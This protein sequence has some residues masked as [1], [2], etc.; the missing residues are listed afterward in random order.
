[1]RLG[2]G[3]WSDLEN[4]PQSQDNIDFYE[5]MGNEFF[6]SFLFYIWAFE[7]NEAK[8]MGISL[9]GISIQDVP[10][11]YKKAIF[12]KKGEKLRS[13]FFYCK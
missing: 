4:V 1:M 10:F 5:V 7:R 11:A 13:S 2:L 12:S 3:G 8:Q 9:I 6:F